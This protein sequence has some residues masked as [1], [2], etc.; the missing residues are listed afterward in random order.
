MAVL[1]V[2]QELCGL[3]DS[4]Q[5]GLS[6][7]DLRDFQNFPSFLRIVGIQISDIWENIG[8]CLDQ[9]DIL[10]HFPRF[11]FFWIGVQ[12]SLTKPFQK[13]IILG[14]FSQVTP[15]CS[16]DFSLARKNGVGLAERWMKGCCW[17][18]WD[19]SDIVDGWNLAP[20]E[21]GSFFHYWQGFIAPRWCRMSS[22]NSRVVLV[23][24]EAAFG[25]WKNM[26][27]LKNLNVQ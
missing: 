19:A 2:D 3:G 21:V 10:Q 22:I 15:G 11:L 23:L 26:G 7:G 24:C 12:I 6:P 16:D 4:E 17:M 9:I 27:V 18:L 25:S 1:N 5:L 13:W 20:V 14:M 8:Y